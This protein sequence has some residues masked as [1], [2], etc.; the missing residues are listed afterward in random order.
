LG[1][2]II[3][4]YQRP[5]ARFRL[6]KLFR[7]Q[8]TAS[9]RS[10]TPQKIFRIKKELGKKKSIEIKEPSVSVISRF[11]REPAV[12]M[13]GPRHPSASSCGQ[14]FDPRPLVVR[15]Q[16]WEPWLYSRIRLCEVFESHGYEASEPPPVSN[17]RPAWFC[18]PM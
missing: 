17:N 1:F 2:L 15:Q 10:L 13:K 8:R 16:N 18:T 14:L 5:Q 9:S 6:F 7:N 12:F 3:W 11:I 4:I